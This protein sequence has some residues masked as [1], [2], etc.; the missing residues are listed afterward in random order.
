MN[1]PEVQ[2]PRFEQAKQ[3]INFVE[4]KDNEA[5]DPASFPLHVLTGDTFLY[6]LTGGDAAGIF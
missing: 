6:L 3:F 2:T 5:P 1:I 4:G